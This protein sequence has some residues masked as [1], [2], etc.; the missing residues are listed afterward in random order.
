MTTTWIKL[1]NILLD[2]YVTVL[3]K[4]TLQTLSEYV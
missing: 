3:V 2:T 1:L 4:V